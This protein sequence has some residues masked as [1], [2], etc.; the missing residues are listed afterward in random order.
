MLSPL[1]LFA[2]YTGTGSVSQGVAT[3]VNSN[4]FPG[5]TGSRVAAVGTITSTDSRVWTVPS[6][7]H[8]ATG[9]Y[10]PD[11]YNQCA[12]IV[13]ANI[14]AVNVSAIPTVV[15]DPGGA[16]ITG[17]IFG[18]NYFELYINGVLVGVDPVPYTP[19]NSCIVKFQVNYP[20]TIAIKLVDWEENLGVGS[21]LNGGNPYHAG[22]G[23]FIASFSDGTATSQTWKAQ[24]F[25][26]A[27]IEDLSQVVEL[28]DST[29][30]TAS[31]STSPGCNGGC[32]AI[33]YPIPSTWNSVAFND[34]G[35]PNATEF[36]EA[37][38]GVAGTLAYTNFSSLWSTAK[39]IWSSNL[40]LDNEVLVRHTVTVPSSVPDFSSL[41]KTIHI[42]PNPMRDGFHLDLSKGVSYSDINKIS[43]C[44]LYGE[45]IFETQNIS[46]MVNIGNIP[47]GLYYLIISLKDK[48]YSQL[49][50][51]Q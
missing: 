27:P 23:G 44:N 29:R 32:Y 48:Q 1:A 39:F 38:V 33:H 7:T 6:I 47:I 50:T 34:A 18:D 13:P 37:T 26:I 11:L 17:Y 51:I 49:I 31:A 41:S 35:W 30:S 43:I 40:I 3:I 20:Y 25:Y 15:I 9:P 28:S 24:T 21:E 16:I 2:Q 4:L 14:S 46:Q 42:Y 8:Y 12:G 22:D 36:S 5:C 45:R 10:L 19:F